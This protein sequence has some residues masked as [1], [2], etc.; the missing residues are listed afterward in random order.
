MRKGVLCEYWF[1][2]TDAN[3]YI[4]QYGHVDVH[5]DVWDASGAPYGGFFVEASHDHE[6]PVV[7]GQSIYILGTVEATWK[8]RPGAIMWCDITDFYDQ[9]HT[10]N[11][12][13]T[14]NFDL[15]ISSLKSGA[16][17]TTPYDEVK[18]SL[19]IP[20]YIHQREAHD[21]I[22]NVLWK[23]I[24]DM[25]LNDLETEV[26]NRFKKNILLK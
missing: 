15:F 8:A 10:Y 13:V 11:K 17:L 21:S 4:D 1:A 2:F 16:I 7:Q 25:P 9:R 24:N 26:M 5:S 14:R 18:R 6:V 12:F 20:A 3:E 22:Y 23:A 19:Q